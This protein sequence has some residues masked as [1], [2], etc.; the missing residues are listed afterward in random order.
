MKSALLLLTLLAVISPA[1]ASSSDALEGA[2]TFS[3]LSA[4]DKKAVKAI[5]EN[6]A[7]ARPDIPILEIRSSELT[8]FYDVVLPAGQILHF[9][10][11]G[12]NFFAGDLYSVNPTGLVN[13]SETGRNIE[14]RR[15][16]D[17][18][19]ESEMLVFAPPKEL[20]KATITVFTDIDCVYCRKLHT[21]VPEMN[22]LGIAVRYLAYP[23][24]GTNS[25]SYEKLV[26]AWCADNPKIALTRAKNGKPIEHVT[27]DNPVAAQYEL[28][29]RMGVNSTPSILLEDGTLSPGYLPAQKLA[30]E[31]G[32]L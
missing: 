24:A 2:V 19:D 23:R 25:E 28:G 6:L 18:L 26:S 27:C 5:T 11:D 3:E 22:R 31:L 8:G 29:G 4:A 14:R 30:E 32:I 21:E 15:L 16:M 1:F 17:E 7:A 12:K 9:T 20:I 10:A 13:V